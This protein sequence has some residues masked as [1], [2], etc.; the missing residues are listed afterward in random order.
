MTTSPDTALIGQPNTPFYDADD[1]LLYVKQGPYS[2]EE[3]LA[4]DIEKYALDS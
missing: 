4:A 3:H 2:A 1:E